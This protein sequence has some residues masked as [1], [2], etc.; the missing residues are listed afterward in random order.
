MHEKPTASPPSGN[1]LSTTRTP[2]NNVVNLS[3]YRPEPSLGELLTDLH[4]KV[5]KLQNALG[6]LGSSL[7]SRASSR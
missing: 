1:D 6:R 2:V 7:Q 5:D 4:V 3:D